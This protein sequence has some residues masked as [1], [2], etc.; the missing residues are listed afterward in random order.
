MLDAF[1]KSGVKPVQLQADELQALIAASKE[2][3]AALNTMLT[4][5]QLHSARLASA[6]KTLQEVEE[7]AGKA[8]IRIDEVSE[9]L[10]RADGKAK[11][12]EAV[13]ARIK[14]LAD[15]VGRAEKE[16]VRLTAPDGELQKHKQALQSLSSQALQTRASLDTLKKDQAALEELR[17]QLRHAQT[18]I[19]ESSDRTDALKGDFDQLRALSGQLAQDY[20]RLK[21]VSRESH[22]EA[23]AAVEIVKDVEKKLGPLAQLQEMS[24]TTEERTAA[25]NALAE[26]VGQKIKALENQKHTVEH[27]VV[28]ANR[29]NE[30]I[31]NM[32]VQINKL[33]EAG[34]QATR[35][36]ELVDRVEKLARDVG[37]QLDTGNKARETFAMDLAKL[38]KDRVALGDFVRGYTDRLTVERKEFDAFDQRVKAL[39][40]SVGEAEK[41]MESLAARDR[42]AAS[43]G[44]RVDQLA[45]QMQALTS[46]ADELTRK[47]TSLDTLHDSLGKVD[48]L[49]T[50]T[51][52]Q[53]ENLKQSRGDLDVLRKE[54]QEFYKSHAAAVQLRDRLGADRTALEAFIERTTTFSAGL[55]ELDARMS[56]ITSKLAIVDEGTHKAANLV[57]IADDLDRQMSRIA[58]QQQFVERVESRLNGLNVLSAEV[59]RKLDDQIAR[60]AEVE[61][62]RSQID[63][64]AIQVADAQ[65]KLEAVGALQNKLLPLTSQLSMLKSQIEKAHARFVA[66]QKEQT[67]LADQEKRLTE[68][69]GATRTVAEQAGERLKQVQGLA[70]EVGRSAAIKDELLQELARVQGRQRD[71]AAQIDSSADQLERLEAMGK[72]IDQRRSQL[73]F[74]EKRIAAFEERLGELAQMT[75]D[76]DQKIQSLAQREA[77]VEAVRGEVAGVHEISARS[78]ADLQYV[79]AH[80]SEVAVL[81]ERVDETL[82]CIGETESRLAAIEGRKRLVDEVH[83]KTSVISNMLEDVR[84]NFET[85]GEQKAV[86]DHVME[87]FNRLAEKV[88]EAQTT[89]KSLQAERELAERIERGIKRLRKT[90]PAAADPD[91]QRLA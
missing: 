39:Q 7:K 88:Q 12:L 16:A 56:A 70:E 20:G 40:T 34:R 85:L 89:L 13:D 15:A 52:A 63:G 54:I 91:K 6:G 2:E 81:R 49:A 10:T 26:H 27:A 17:E 3:R 45:K 5:V 1:K 41:G 43:M 72:Q 44:Q 29:L 67:E 59:D 75:G 87:N 82:G 65:Q 35:T 37:G 60:R 83:L 84:L 31:W 32:E 90:A 42:L 68:M 53:H 51:A 69:L 86:I 14:S 64:V 21:D 4:Q 18:E 28:E 33:N 77:I 25:L 66:A 48:D 74:S 79:D 11:E 24:K 61:A 58:S 73:A 30:M 38:E 36:E 46:Q 71:I 23:N 8:Q 9:R 22:E 50:R 47:Q 62:L 55:P 57:T 80:R 19:K 76:I 78:R